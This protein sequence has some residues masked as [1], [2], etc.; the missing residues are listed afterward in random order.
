[1]L[2]LTPCCT[3]SQHPNTHNTQSHIL[4]ATHTFPRSARL[5]PPLSFAR[6]AHTHTQ[7]RRLGCAAQH[8]LNTQQ[9]EV[10]GRSHSCSFSDCGRGWDTAT[11]CQTRALKHPSPPFVTPPHKHA[12]GSSTTSTISTTARHATQQSQPLAA[13]LLLADTR[14]S[15]AL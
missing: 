13:A 7:T 10:A 9:L 14:A 8:L 4:C 3:L 15:V 12:D 11:S 5:A 1:M 6:T 2:A